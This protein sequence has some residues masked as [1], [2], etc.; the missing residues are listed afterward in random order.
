MH[1]APDALQCVFDHLAHE[2]GIRARTLEVPCS[3]QQ[4][5]HE[6][7]VVDRRLDD[8]AGLAEDG[9]HDRRV[10]LGGMVRDN[11]ARSV[12]QPEPC[13]SP[14]E[15]DHAEGAQPPMQNAHAARAGA[16]QDPGS[17]LFGA[18]EEEPKQRVGQQTA[19]G[20]DH[21]EQETDHHPDRPQQPP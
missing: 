5:V 16:L 1:S 9:H 19:R 20:H 6:N 15:V 7:P 3:R 18:A 11:H 21:V 14:V 8:R 10:E 12:R 4:V 13:V 2:H 17:L